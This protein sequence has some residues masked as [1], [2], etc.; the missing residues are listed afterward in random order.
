[1]N[2]K[3][4]ELQEQNNELDERINQENKAIFTDMIC[5]LRGADISGYQQEVVRRDL[6]EMILSAQERGETIHDVIGTDCKEFCDDV[7]ASLPPRTRREKV[8]DFLDMI[9]MTLPILGV[10]NIAFSSNFHMMLLGLFSG[11]AVNYNI[12]ITWG[13]IIAIVLIIGVSF[14]VVEKIMRNALQGEKKQKRV[15]NGFLI[16]AG[17]VTLFLLIAKLGRTA[18]FSVNIF[19]ALGFILLLYVCHKLLDRV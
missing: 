4:K 18:I 7:I 17:G 3:V 13:D 5:Y 6:S 14:F 15:K 16:G 10:I 2:R 1:M 9:C 19:L 11:K 12:S 8:L